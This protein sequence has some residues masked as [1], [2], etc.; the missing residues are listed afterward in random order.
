MTVEALAKHFRATGRAY[1]MLDVARNVMAARERYQVAIQGKAPVAKKQAARRNESPEEVEQ[2]AAAPVEEKAPAP[3]AA[4]LVRCKIDGSLWLTREEAV[5]HVLASE[6][7]LGEFYVIEEVQVEAP[8]GNFSSIAVCGMSGTL[9]GPPNH[10]EY[11]TNLAKLH[12][13]RFANM[14]FERFKARVQMK[15]D[16]ESIE[17]W[18]QSVSVA[19]HFRV[20]PPQVAVEAKVEAEELVQAEAS[21][22]AAAP[23]TE[24]TVDAVAEDTG[25]ETHAEEVAAEPEEAAQEAEPESAEAASEESAGEVSEEAISADYESAS[26]SEP[27]AEAELVITSERDLERHFRENFANKILRTVGGGIV[28]GDVPGRNLSPPLLEKL[29]HE[30]DRMRNGFPL[31]LIQTLCRRLEKLGV[32]FFKRDTKELFASMAR[33]RAIRDEGGMT[34]RVRNIVE[35][36]RAYPKSR[37]PKLLESLIE[38]FIAPRNEEEMAGHTPSADEMSMLRDIRWLTQEGYLIEYASG[39]L[40]LGQDEPVKKAGP[41]AGP[42]RSHGGKGKQKQA[43]EGE[44]KTAAGAQGAP[45]G[46]VSAAG[47]AAPT[48]DAVSE[49]ATGD[50]GDGAGV[51]SEAAPAADPVGEDMPPAPK[52]SPAPE[53]GSQPPAPAKGVADNSEADRPPA[54]KAPPEQEA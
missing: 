37:V 5:R 1:S 20:K 18:K 4:K 48:A 54:P 30:T 8:K 40:V 6:E 21:D 41:A 51:E 9:L 19:K 26:E 33:P 38:G 15:S 43:A 45:A 39:D 29:K 2:A 52:P 27:E 16:E 17:A 7:L 14:P 32:K 44:K 28:S 47:E 46:E 36:V 34:D 25:A 24:E 49:T 22:S 31:P 10:H 13:E 12:R 53:A 35:Y 50:D 23:E 11:Q 3:E 42:A